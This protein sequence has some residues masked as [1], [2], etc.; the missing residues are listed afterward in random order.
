MNTSLPTMRHDFPRAL[1]VDLAQ[2]YG[3]ET[4]T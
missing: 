2:L 3:V 4:G 1:D